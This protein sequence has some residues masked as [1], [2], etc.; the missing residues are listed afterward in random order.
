M[1]KKK[2]TFEVKIW[3]AV[4]Q[5]YHIE[6]ASAEEAEELVKDGDGFIVDDTIERWME[7]NSG[8]GP[9]QS[10]KEMKETKAKIG[11]LEVK[12]IERKG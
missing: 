12:I 7:N 4:L 3:A 8:G 5:T 2:K 11:D 9:V 1:K 6:A 10:V